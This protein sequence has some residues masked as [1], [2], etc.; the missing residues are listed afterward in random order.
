MQQ[1]ESF[2]N[3]WQKKSLIPK[4]RSTDMAADVKLHNHLLIDTMAAVICLTA[5]LCH[6]GEHSGTFPHANMQLTSH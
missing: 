1:F 5:S 3:T 6:Q 4:T 2:R